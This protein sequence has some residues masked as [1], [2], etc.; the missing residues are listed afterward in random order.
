M[1]YEH[2]LHFLFQCIQLILQA[3]HA[4][5]A[6]LGIP[7]VQPTRN[8]MHWKH[9]VSNSAPATCPPPAAVTPGHSFLTRS[10]IRRNG[11]AGMEIDLAEHAGMACDTQEW[12]CENFRRPSGEHAGMG[13]DLA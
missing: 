6:P 8:A 7:T 11:H 12:N 5:K 13:M 2:S 9:C 10:E 3:L 4:L 1:L